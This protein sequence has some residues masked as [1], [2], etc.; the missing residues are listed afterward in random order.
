MLYHID[1]TPEIPSD[2]FGTGGKQQFTDP[3][4]PTDRAYINYWIK[5]WIDLCYDKW[6]KLYWSQ[7]NYYAWSK[8]RIMRDYLHD[9]YVKSITFWSTVELIED[10]RLLKKHK[11]FEYIDSTDRLIIA[12]CSLIVFLFWALV[13][14][15]I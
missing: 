2:R 1:N 9:L 7:D 8:E 12:L 11:V 14:V 4:D 15:L 5:I 13:F 6:R 10:N 3:V